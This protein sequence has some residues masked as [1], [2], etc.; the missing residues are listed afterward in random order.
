[1]EQ[2]HITELQQGWSLNADSERLLSILN[3]KSQRLLLGILKES[4]DRESVKL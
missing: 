3:R 2:K 4:D 1:M